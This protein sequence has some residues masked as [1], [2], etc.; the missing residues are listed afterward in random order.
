MWEK[1]KHRRTEHSYHWPFF[2]VHRNDPQVTVIPWYNGKYRDILKNLPFA[3]VNNPDKLPVGQLKQSLYRKKLLKLV[4]DRKWEWRW[5]FAGTLNRHVFSGTLKAVL[6]AYSDG[7]LVS[8]YRTYV[9][10]TSWWPHWTTAPREWSLTSFLN[11][12]KLLFFALEIKM[13][14]L[15]QI[16]M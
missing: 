16:I 10:S 8:G 2:R 15:L 5:I 3:L 4:E 7:I 13:T 6:G 11:I 1:E 9:K 14:N 12:L